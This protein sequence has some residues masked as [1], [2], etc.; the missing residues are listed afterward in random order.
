MDEINILI[1]GDFVPSNRVYKLIE[2]GDFVDAF[3]QV[4]VLTSEVDYS[5]VNLEAPIVLDDVILPKL[6]SGPNLKASIKTIDALKYVGFNCVTLANNHLCDY[7]DEGVRN[8]ISSCVKNNI[9]YVGAGENIEEAKKILYKKIKNKTIAFVNF[10][11]EEFSIATEYMP[12]ACPLNIVNNTYQIQEAK[13]KADYVIVIVHGGVEMYRYPTPRMQ[14]TYRFFVDMGADVVINHH[15]HCYSG[16]ERYKEKLIFYGIGNFCFDKGEDNVLWNEGYIVKL[17]FVKGNNNIEFN[18]LPYVQ[19]AVDFAGVRLMNVAETAKFQ[20]D[21]DK[22]NEVIN[23]ELLEFQFEE[24]LNKVHWGRILN[25]EPIYNK[26]VRFLQSKNILPHLLRKKAY[27]DWYNRL[28]CETHRE[29]LLNI[30]YKKIY[31]RYK[32]KK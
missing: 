30:L 28:N 10:C 31:G 17:S 3:S 4:R 29:V 1:A 19:G 25:L 8:T 12:G 9:D 26:Y 7:G 20:S 2:K 24:Y 22:I 5:I 11:E 21:I 14:E 18:I 23:S 27:L 32:N 15:Q 16:F 6:K 13:R